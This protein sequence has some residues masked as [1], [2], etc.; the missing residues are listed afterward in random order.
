L[1]FTEKYNSSAVPVSTISQAA[2]FSA[3]IKA[4]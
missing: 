3:V 4:G 1:V 2:V